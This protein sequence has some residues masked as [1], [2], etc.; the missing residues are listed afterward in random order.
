MDAVDDADDIRAAAVALMLSLRSALE[1]TKL[2]ELKKRLR[3]LGAT[4][5][6]MDEIDDAPDSKSAAV[7]LL[8]QLAATNAGAG[9]GPGAASPG[10][11]A[12]APAQLRHTQY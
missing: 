11:A 12:A 4:D 1:A 9:A 7:Q 3:T 8:L 6:Q 5:D 10:P 2:S